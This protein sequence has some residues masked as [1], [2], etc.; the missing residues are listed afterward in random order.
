MKQRTSGEGT[1]YKRKD[2]RYEAAIYM[3]TPEG[4]KRVRRY[5]DTRVKA[6][7]ILGQLR[8]KMIMVY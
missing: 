1:V 4:I 3:N 5:A 6:E 2:G 8:L 7:A